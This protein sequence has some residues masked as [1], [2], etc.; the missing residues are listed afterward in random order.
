MR[1]SASR[2]RPPFVTRK[3]DRLLRFAQGWS[4]LARLADGSDQSDREGRGWESVLNRCRVLAT[5]I[6]NELRDKRPPHFGNKA[7]LEGIHSSLES[8]A[9]VLDTVNGPQAGG[10]PRRR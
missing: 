1:E 3:H 7:S 8:V 6:G 2:W 4:R 10:R 9:D 5:K